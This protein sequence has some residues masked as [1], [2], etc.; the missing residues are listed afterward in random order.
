MMVVNRPIEKRTN[1]QKELQVAAISKK[2]AVTRK[3]SQ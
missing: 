2:K 1:G 3:V